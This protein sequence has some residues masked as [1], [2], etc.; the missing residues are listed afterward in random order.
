VYQMC[1]IGKLNYVAGAE[2]PK[3]YLLMSNS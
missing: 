1:K 2:V 3:R